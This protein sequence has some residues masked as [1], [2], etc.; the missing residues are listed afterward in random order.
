M[1]GLRPANSM[2]RHYHYG[3]DKKPHSMPFISPVAP[4]A[5]YST[6]FSQKDDLKL[7]PD[8]SL[9]RPGASR[10][11]LILL[12]FSPRRKKRLPHSKLPLPLLE[13]SDDLP[14]PCQKY[15]SYRKRHGDDDVVYAQQISISIITAI[16][17]SLKLN[18][19]A[20]SR[21]Y[22]LDVFAAT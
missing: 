22:F 18:T 8:Y 17:L 21:A 15:T 6:P 2:L 3:P 10:I 11:S 19:H 1:R 16:Y 4:A 12:H 9:F 5:Y 20:S 13:V 14:R 7:M